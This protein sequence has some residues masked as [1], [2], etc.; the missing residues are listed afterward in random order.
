MNKQT[1]L[2]LI[3]NFDSFTFNLQHL[4]QVEKNVNLEVV[5]NNE[6]FLNDVSART[7]DGVIIG[8]GPGSPEDSEYF[9]NCQWVLDNFDRHQTPILGICLGFQ[10]IYSTFGGSL[11]ISNVP[12]HGKTSSLKINENGSILEGIPEHAKVMR[13]HSILADVESIS[14]SDLVILAESETS[15]STDVNGREIMAIRHI[16]L[17]IYG[18]QFHPESFATELGSQY[19]KNF[20]NLS[21]SYQETS[22]SPDKNS[23]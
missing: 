4:F 14:E 23:L 13:Y 6:D 2:L 22:N 18:L 7:Y 5:R 11:R 15:D 1:R 19:A 21:C 16:D 20:I 17:P 8:P 9:G 3:D 10:G 12:M